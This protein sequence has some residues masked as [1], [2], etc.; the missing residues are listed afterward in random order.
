MTTVVPTRPIQILKTEPKPFAVTMDKD[1]LQPL[2]PILPA[3]AWEIP[4][5]RMMATPFPANF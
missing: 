3:S 1:L 5:G 2:I 4:Y